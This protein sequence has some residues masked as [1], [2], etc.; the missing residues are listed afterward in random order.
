M[1]PYG[2][3][4]AA[5]EMFAIELLELLVTVGAELDDIALDE[6]VELDNCAEEEFAEIFTSDE[7]DCVASDEEGCCNSVED[8]CCNSA[9][10]FGNSEDEAGFNS[11]DVGGA[12]S[13]GPLLLSPQ[14][15]RKAA[16]ANRN[17]RP[18]TKLLKYIIPP[19]I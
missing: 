16:N 5:L 1:Q 18:G 6:S 11:N 4:I 15:A 8:G 7:D 13:T 10:D 19:F 3:G 14:P 2:T 9:D 12:K 17:V